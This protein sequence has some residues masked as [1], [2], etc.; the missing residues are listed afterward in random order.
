MVEVSEL[1]LEER[2]KV[3]EAVTEPKR[4]LKLLWAK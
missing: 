2:P 4:T 1:Q 3:V